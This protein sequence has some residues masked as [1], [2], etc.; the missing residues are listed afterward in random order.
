MR[1][2]DEIR[3]WVNKLEPKLK[4]LL[5]LSALAD[6]IDRE[7]VELP[8][9]RDGVPIRIG[10]VVYGNPGISWT[11]VGLRMSKLGWKVEMGNMPFLCEPDDLT[12]EKPDSLERV[13]EDIEAAEDWCDG[14]GEY[15]TG[16]TSVK[17]STLR[18]WA[19]RIRKLA[20][21]EDE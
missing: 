18:E 21:K 20:A 9:D 10:D 6:R 11:V 1:I 13:A 16:V 12:H 4:S 17:E 2:S 14:E 7:L 8:K 3:D 15:G 19:E 5:E